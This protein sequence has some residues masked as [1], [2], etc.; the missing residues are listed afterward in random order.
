M[1]E[2]ISKVPS[3]KFVISE[4]R[5]S[6]LMID[7]LENQAQKFEVGV[8]AAAQVGV[9]TEVQSVNNDDNFTSPAF[10]A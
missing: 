1:V 7:N 9:A 6:G 3:R 2:K 5:V 4:F 10:S 8:E